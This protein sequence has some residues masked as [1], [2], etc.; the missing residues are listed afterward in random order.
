MT[1]GLQLLWLCYFVQ[2]LPFG[3]QSKSLPLLLKEQG[4]TLRQI[5][6]ANVLSAPW[7]FK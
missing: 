4:Y 5:G 6:Y 7:T 1:G 2:G 3:F